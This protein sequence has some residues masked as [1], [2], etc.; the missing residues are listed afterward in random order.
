MEKWEDWTRATWAI[1]LQEPPTPVQMG[2][3]VHGVRNPVDRYQLPTLWCLHLFTY[4]ATLFIDGQE[5][6]TRPGFACVIPPNVPVSYHYEGR[7]VHLYAHF[8]CAAPSAASPPVSIPVMQDCGSDFPALYARFE[9]VVRAP[10]L[11]PHRRQARLWDILGYLAERPVAAS[12]PSATPDTPPAVQRVMEQ[13]ELR[14][15]EPLS[16]ERLAQE[17]GV[18]YSYISRL[19]QTHLEVTV[20][21]YIRQRRVERAAHLLTHS[22]LPIKSVAVA[23]GIPDLHLF[24]KTIRGALGKSPR[25]VRESNREYT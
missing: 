12:V 19:F 23:V 9:E 7:S 4:R 25:A 8:V 5:F 24:N 18:S 21:G 3:G 22:T 10:R 2:I 17:A 16:V 6:P 15:G 14:L 1:P 11:P 20:V 13:I